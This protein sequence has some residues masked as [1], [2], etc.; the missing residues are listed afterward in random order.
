MSFHS[1]VCLGCAGVDLMC[2]GQPCLCMRVSSM[3][4]YKIG[5]GG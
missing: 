4:M 2:L 5:F 3:F 1:E